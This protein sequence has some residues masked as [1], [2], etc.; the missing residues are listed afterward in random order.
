MKPKF[1]EGLLAAVKTKDEAQIT[2]AIVKAMDESRE[3][4]EAKKKQEEDAKDKARDARTVQ[5]VTDAIAAA[6]K[7]RD[8]KEAEE[9]KKAEDKA[10]DDEKEEAER[11]KKEEDDEIEQELEEESGSKDT[12]KAKDSALLSESFETV[13]MLAEIVSP[14]VQIPTFDAKAD[15]RKTFRDCHC[16]L[17]RKALQGAVADAETSQLVA[18]VRG[19]ALDAAEI[20]Q[21][22]CGQVR[23]IFNGVAAMKR[24]T[25]NGAATRDRLAVAQTQTAT[26]D[27]RTPTQRFIDAAK[28]R[29]K[30]S[31]K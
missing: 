23:T 21:L 29:K 4:E 11:K 30:A 6:F 20:P 10:K 8:E 1:F 26:T 17:R 7:A 15:P 25:N 31:F 28:E 9:K 27:H 19:R 3:E 18:T 24:A 16:N 5:L 22:S 13:K 2:A 14:G 12:A